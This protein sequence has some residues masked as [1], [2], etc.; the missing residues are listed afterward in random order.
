MALESDRERGRRISIHLVV[1]R[2]LPP[3]ICDGPE[4]CIKR[5]LQLVVICSLV[6]PKSVNVSVGHLTQKSKSYFQ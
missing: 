5:V 1:I 4:I 6:A 2:C 3:T